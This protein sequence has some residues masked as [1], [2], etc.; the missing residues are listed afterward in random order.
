MQGQAFRAR[1]R[2]GTA[3]VVDN[4][5]GAGGGN[6]HVNALQL[7]LWLLASDIVCRQGCCQAVTAQ[8]PDDQFRLYAAGHYGHRYRRAIHDLDSSAPVTALW[9]LPELW[10]PFWRAPAERT[11]AASISEPN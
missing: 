8:H 7:Q 9:P 10:S 5:A 6:Q 11:M 1:L 3:T 2:E 4:A